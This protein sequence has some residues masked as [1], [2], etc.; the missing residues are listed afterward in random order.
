MF[1]FK[2]SEQCSHS[3]DQ[4]CEDLKEYSLQV[5]AS[6]TYLNAA[7]LVD[8]A[9]LQD[10]KNNTNSMSCDVCHTRE[11]LDILHRQQKNSI[12]LTCNSHE[13][14]HD[15]KSFLNQL[16]MDLSYN[17]SKLFFYFLH[18]AAGS[19]KTTLIRYIMRHSDKCK[20]MYIT[21]KSILCSKVN[22]CKYQHPF[23]FGNVS[24]L[25][26][27]FF[28]Y[29]NASHTKLKWKL[30]N[31]ILESDNSS[32]DVENFLEKN[33]MSVDPIFIPKGISKLIIFFD[34]YSMLA[35]I[36][37]YYLIKILSCTLGS[38]R[39]CNI[40]L[41]F[42]GDKNQCP[43]IGRNETNYFPPLI[44][45]CREFETKH[46][47]LSEHVRYTDEELKKFVQRIY[48][49]TSSIG[50]ET[51]QFDVRKH[52][53]SIRFENNITKKCIPV[54]PLCVDNFKILCKTNN[55]CN[56]YWQNYIRCLMACYPECNSDILVINCPIESNQKGTKIQFLVRN[57]KYYFVTNLKVVNTGLVEQLVNH[58]E[59]ILLDIL[60]ND[61][62]SVK[63]ILV[64]RVYDN[65]KFI[66]KPIW[67]T[68]YWYSKEFK[69]YGFPI[70]PSFIDNIFQMQGLTIT[71]DGY[72]DFN[73]CSK[74]EDMYTAI[75]RFQHNQQI[76]GIINL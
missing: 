47:R 26:K 56:M 48:L 75:T 42:V 16:N 71:V 60:E 29:T 39:L 14:N 31:D 68:E 11:E 45:Y 52:L 21:I 27:F 17:K 67:Y 4:L 20:F 3:E 72:I 58:E 49:S 30:T 53:L 70:H 59:C 50:E 54:K 65:L 9:N 2:C 19:G 64:Q 61:D 23:Q 33:N 35:T 34:E 15:Q 40:Y 36:K 25:A 43:P 22:D 13:L 1:E 7:S 12:L 44:E 69:I 28:N 38:Y 51:L 6:N 32:Y 57:L 55:S 10:N 5:N 37:A 76:K 41:I 24:T 63:G 74:N 8:I 18:G 62:K 73:N 66:V 46:F